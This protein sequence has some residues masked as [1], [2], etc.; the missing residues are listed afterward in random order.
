MKLLEGEALDEWSLHHG[1]MPPLA[2]VALFAQIGEALDQAH[3]AGVIHRDIKP[4]NL[5]LAAM[6]TGDVTLKVI[7]LRRSQVPRSRCPVDGDP[8]LALPPT[9][10]RSSWVLPC[11]CSRRRTGSLSRARWFPPR[12]SGPLG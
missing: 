9:P 12:M 3:G 7:E 5:F 11:A 8:R 1:P 2:L 4:S 10:P 6:P